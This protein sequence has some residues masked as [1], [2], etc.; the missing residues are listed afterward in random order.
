[1]LRRKKDNEL[2]A[3]NDDSI[4]ITEADKKLIA[5]VPAEYRAKHTDKEIINM[6]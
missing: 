3:Q 1:M 4:E 2:Q 5:Q 6:I